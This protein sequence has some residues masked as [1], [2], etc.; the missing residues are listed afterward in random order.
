[1]FKVEP[2]D[3]RRCTHTFERFALPVSP[4]LGLIEDFPDDDPDGSRALSVSGVS[5]NTRRGSR[6]RKRADEKFSQL[7][8][9]GG[10][11]DGI[12]LFNEKPREWEGDYNTIAR[13]GLLDSQTPD[14]VQTTAR[15]NES[16]SVRF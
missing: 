2:F 6:A 15:S 12:H 3:A 1:M 10:V 4:V 11:S 16:G 9:R 5:R 7:I 13:T 8:D 14:P